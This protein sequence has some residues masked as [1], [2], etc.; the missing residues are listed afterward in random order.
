MVFR[1]RQ[2]GFGS[3]RRFTFLRKSKIQKPIF[4]IA[5]NDCM[6]SSGTQTLKDPEE[7]EK[8]ETL[9]NQSSRISLQSDH[10]LDAEP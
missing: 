6:E 7:K 4:V 2:N 10:N 8:E 1:Q 5:E 3:K 9:C